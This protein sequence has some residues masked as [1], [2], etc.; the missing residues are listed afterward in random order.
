MCGFHAGRWY[1]DPFRIEPEG[2]KVPKYVSESD[3]KMV[4]DVLKEANPGAKYA[5]GGGNVGPDVPGIGGSFHLAGDAERLAGIAAGQDVYRPVLAAGAGPVDKAQVAEIPDVG[6]VVGEDAGGPVVG[7]GDPCE[8]P[9]EHAEH[10]LVESAVSGAYGA[11]SGAGRHGELS[12]Y[13]F[14]RRAGQDPVEGG[15]R[16]RAHHGVPHAASFRARARVV[17][18][19]AQ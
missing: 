1:N 14:G 19:A 6:V 7:V 10:G 12:G 17:W 2:G 16:L 15:A 4:C 11:D 3:P 9:T 8:G 5:N 18:H 13:G